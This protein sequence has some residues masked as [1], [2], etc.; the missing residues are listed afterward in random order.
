MSRL[1][2]RGFV[3]IE[4][5][6]TLV[7]FSILAS[8]IA[9]AYPTARDRHALTNA[10]QE[11]QSLLRTAGQRAVNEERDQ[12]CL[13]QFDNAKT[14]SD[15]GLAFDGNAAI[16][17]AD[18]DG[19]YEYTSSDYKI[20]S[21]QLPQQITTVQAPVFVFIAIPPTLSL[22][23][24]A[25]AVTDNQPAAITLTTQHSQAILNVLPYGQITK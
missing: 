5:V 7:I 24:N 21:S 9:T 1:K 25:V 17:F 11:I 14:C 4:L 13:D 10:E 19:N 15:V 22:S 6:V 20:L 12:A 23:A 3:L 18:I 16:M 2:P 8:I